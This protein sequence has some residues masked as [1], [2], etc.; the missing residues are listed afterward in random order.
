MY[1]TPS[2]SL[3]HSRCDYN[4]KHKEIYARIQVSYI[5]FDG[6]YGTPCNIYIDD[7]ILKSDY[8]YGFKMFKIYNICPKNTFIKFSLKEINSKTGTRLEPAT[9]ELQLTEQ[10]GKFSKDRV[11]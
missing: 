4:E 8:H 6:W 9:H 1:Y 3:P 2:R 5:C 11:K 7:W 10:R